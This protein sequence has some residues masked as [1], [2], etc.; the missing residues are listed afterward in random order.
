M[1]YNQY[2]TPY[3][4]T[5]PRKAADFRRIARHALKGFWW[6]AFGV[7]I[8]ATILSG[9]TLSG[10]GSVSIGI[11]GGN[12]PFDMSEINTPETPDVEGSVG[13]IGGAEEGAP[14]VPILTPE[15]AEKFEKALADFDFSAMA[16]IFGDDYPVLALILSSFVLLFVLGTVVAFLLYIFVSSPVK[17]GYQKFCLNVLDGKRSSVTFDSL[18]DY[19]RRGY[20]KSIG[21]NLC[22]SFLLWLTRLPA[23]IGVII[24]SVQFLGTLPAVLASETPDALI[25]SWLAFAGWSLLGSLVTLCIYIPVSYTYSMAHMIMADYSNVGPIEALRL[26]RQMMRG[27]KWRLFCLDFSFIGWILLAICCTCGLG[28]FFIAPYQNVSRAAFYHEISNRTT[29][30]DVEF[31]SIN[32]ED[33]FN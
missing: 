17:V 12:F 19:F 32:P 31:P 14:N 21:L 13:I 10:G 33:Y 29:P 2:Q 18:F 24:G 26:S 4:E 15:K 6:L 27:N 7:T 8:V 5:R 25:L 1:N 30:E 9:V 3:Y 22:H 23:L 16:E 28:A 11:S 20:F